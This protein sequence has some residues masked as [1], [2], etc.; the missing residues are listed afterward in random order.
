[1]RRFAGP[2]E[3]RMGARPHGRSACCSELVMAYKGGLKTEAGGD[4][5]G[6]G[7]APVVPG[8]ADEGAG[9]TY[10][11]ATRIKW[12]E[13]IAISPHPSATSSRSRYCKQMGYWVWCPFS[14]VFQAT[15]S[16]QILPFL[17]KNVQRTGTK[18]GDKAV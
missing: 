13:F 9:Y 10:G 1:M 18:G 5:R 11:R 3:V 17:T 16:Y 7:G 8:G 2:G 6:T 12:G 14:G 15:K 4:Q